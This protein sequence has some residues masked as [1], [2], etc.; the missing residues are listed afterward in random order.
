MATLEQR[1]R[2]LE[3]AR[4]TEGCPACGAGGPGPVR[5]ELDLTPPVDKLPAP[6]PVLARPPPPPC[7]VCGLAPVILTLDLQIPRAVRAEVDDDVDNE[8][9]DDEDDE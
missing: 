6:D 4:P 2:A 8:E 1:L 5:I 9:H 3:A 7:P